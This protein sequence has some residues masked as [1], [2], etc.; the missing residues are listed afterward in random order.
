[1]NIAAELEA[2]SGVW[3]ELTPPARQGNELANHFRTT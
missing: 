1:M 3:A 2:L